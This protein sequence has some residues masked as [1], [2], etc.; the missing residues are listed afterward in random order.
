MTSVIPAPAQHS[1]QHQL[2]SNS[3]ICSEWRQLALSYRN[4]SLLL[5]NCSSMNTQWSNNPQLLTRR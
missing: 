1:R 5:V 3:N 2:L 4:V